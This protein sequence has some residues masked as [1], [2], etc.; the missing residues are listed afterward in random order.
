MS[1]PLRRDGADGIQTR[2]ALADGGVIL[3]DH[4]I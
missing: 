1:G 3:A 2:V 4:F